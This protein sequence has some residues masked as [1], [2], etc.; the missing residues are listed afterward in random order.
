M[1]T[2]TLRPNAAG[3]LT[4]IHNQ[5]PA[6]GSHWDKVDEAVADEDATYVD[7]GG[8]ITE[9]IDLY[10]LPAHS[11]GCGVINH[12]KVYVRCRHYGVGGGGYAEVRIKTNGAVKYGSQNAL[13]NSWTTYSHQWDTNPVTAA[14]WTWDEIDALQIGVKLTDNYGN[15]E[16]RCTQV[17]VEIDYTEVPLLTTEAVDDITQTTATFNGT[18][19]DVGE[20]NPTVRGFVFDTESHN[21]PGN[22][23][24]ADSEYF[25]PST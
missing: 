18:V 11:T 7:T 14:P 4:G 24:P 1:T 13:T 8:Y 9:D 17:Y 25:D 3:D 22:V 5:Y 15:D 10:N 2:E 21:D 23:A 19:T 6:T 16:V 12:I 20:A